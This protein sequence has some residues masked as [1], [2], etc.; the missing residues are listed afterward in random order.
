MVGHQ[1]ILHLLLYE[2]SYGNRNNLQAENTPKTGLGEGG[3]RGKQCQRKSE[4]EQLQRKSVD[5]Y[6]I[7]LS[8]VQL[9]RGKDIENYLQN[10]KVL[11]CVWNINEQGNL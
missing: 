9:V 7:K 3:G 10:S 2:K 5:G 1:K 6:I 11:F 4:S 8:E